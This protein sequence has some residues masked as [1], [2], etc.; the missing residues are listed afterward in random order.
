MDGLDIVGMI[1]SPRPSHPTGIDVVGND[2]VIVRELSLAERA[3]TVLG[4]DLPVHQLS[5]LGVRADLSI[6][7]RVLRIVNATDAHLARSS[8]LRN[9]FPSAASL[10]SVN[11]AQLI[12]AESHGS[13]PR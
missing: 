8:F 4:G 6:S 11:R 1:I 3:H 9:R 10:R 5:H 12:S 13:L 2:V 7:T